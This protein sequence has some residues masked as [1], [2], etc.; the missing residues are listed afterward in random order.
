MMR[1]AATR[2]DTHEW[3]IDNVMQAIKKGDNL[4]CFPC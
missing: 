4:Q 2:K 1:S 3:A